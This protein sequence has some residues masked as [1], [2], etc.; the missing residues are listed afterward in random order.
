[1]ER[2]WWKW[3]YSSGWSF[4]WGM[5]YYFFNVRVYLFSAELELKTS[6]FKKSDL[7]V[8]LFSDFSTSSS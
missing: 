3:F 1:M 5:H 8:L 4:E 2:R 6:Y 7:T